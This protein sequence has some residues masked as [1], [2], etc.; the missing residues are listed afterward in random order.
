M[1]FLEKIKPFVY[2]RIQR[3]PKPI[4]DEYIKVDFMKIFTDRP[5]LIAEI[6]FASPSQ[7]IL[8]NS[9]RNAIDIA[10]LYIDNGA[11]AIS[12][13][14]E[15]HFF[16][17]DIQI[18]SLLRKQFLDLPILLK[19]FILETVQIDEAVAAG[20]SAILL[21]AGLINPKTLRKLYYHAL[22]RNVTPLIEVHDQTEL[23]SILPLE[24]AVIGINNRNLNTLKIDLET[25]KQ[26]L[27][28][29]PAPIQTI[30]E[31]GLQ[32]LSQLQA[33]AQLGCNGFLIGSSIISNPDMAK[34]LAS[35]AR[36]KYER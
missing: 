16:K 28:R 13:V 8:Y 33:L 36:I 2:E 21:I 32:H 3:I 15:P 31:S 35:L 7:G 24:P 26:L 34:Q 19:D 5:V 25:S 4:L 9:T 22:K 20:A 12:V 29:I 18:V 1:N 14:T 17:G 11:D 30:S 10:Q 6:K 23:E 27:P